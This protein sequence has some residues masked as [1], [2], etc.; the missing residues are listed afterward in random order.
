M[1]P[2]P[3]ATKYSRFGSIHNISPSL[4]RHFMLDGII[5]TIIPYPDL[6]CS[7][8]TRLFVRT[9]SPI[10]NFGKITT[11]IITSP[12]KKPQVEKNYSNTKQYDH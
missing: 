6:C 11:L 9:K 5:S 12:G 7:L 1:P 10:E 8:F 4:Q 3:R 2:C